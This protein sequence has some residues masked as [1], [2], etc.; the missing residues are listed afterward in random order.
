MRQLWY[1][2]ISPPYQLLPQSRVSRTKTFDAWMVKWREEGV[3]PPGRISDRSTNPH[4]WEGGWSNSRELVGWLLELTDS[5]V[6]NRKHWPDQDN[7]P[8]VYVEKDTLSG[9]IDRAVGDLG[10]VVYRRRES[11]R[12]RSSGSWPG[13]GAS[14]STS[15]TSPITTPP[16]CS[17]AATSGSASRGMA[18]PR[19]R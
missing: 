13:S 6:Y 8:I 18:G 15:S 9:T 17:W 19:S 2:L 5:D 10:V 14:V 4:G 12:S 7:V 3:I 11:R 16:G 1:R